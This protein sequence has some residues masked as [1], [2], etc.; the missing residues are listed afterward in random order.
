M[1]RDDSAPDAAPDLERMVAAVG[2]LSA[3]RFTVDG[4][5]CAGGPAAADA[6]DG[7]PTL[8]G[9]VPVV[10]KLAREIYHR[11]YTRGGAAG[12]RMA[13]AV[14]RRDH[15]VR[16]SQANCGRGTWEP[17]WRISGPQEDG[18]VAVEK[19]G[20]TFWV[21]P[22]RLRPSDGL[23]PGS[24][25]RVK[26][27]KELRELQRGFY[28]AV[29]DGGKDGEEDE[30]EPLARFYWH[31]TAAGA[32]PFVRLLTASLNP[33]GIAFRAKVLSD[34]VSY[35]R[36]D[37]G[38]LYL[39]RR[40]E[41]ALRDTIA[42]VWRGARGD[43]RPMVPLLTRQLAP[44]LGVAEDPGDG[45]SFG[46][47]R[48]ILV[49]RGLWRAFQQERRTDA[50]RLA[51]VVETFRET[52]LDPSRPHLAPGSADSYLP[53]V[54]APARDPEPRRRPA[55]ASP[56]TLL[57]AA[58]NI[59]DALVARA[60]W[61]EEKCNWMG[62]CRDEAAAPHEPVIPTSAALGCS[63]YDG[64]PG[65]ALFLAE[66][67]A[68][69]GGESY[70]RTAR[71]A[72]RQAL[73]RLRDEPGVLAA[74]GLFAGRLGVAWAAG[75][76]AELCAADDL[77]EDA[78]SLLAATVAAL[79]TPA[80]GGEE[81]PSDLLAGNAGGIL[82]LLHLQRRTA[83]Q[84]LLAAAVTLGDELCSRAR[85]TGTTWSWEPFPAAGLAAGPPLTG[86][87]HGAAGIGLALME[88]FAATGRADFLT[89][90][91]RAFAYEAELFDAARRNW[92]DLRVYESDGRREGDGE[93]TFRT[94]WCHGAPGIVLSR[95]RALELD[96]EPS[97]TYRDEAEAGLGT[98]LRVLDRLQETSGSDA[99]L[100]HGVAGLGEV[101]LLAGQVL[102][103]KRY[104][105]RAEEA[106]RKLLGHHGEKGDWPSGAPSR[107]PNPS[108]LLGDAGIGHWLLRL[109]AG[110]AVP[111]VLLPFWNR[112]N[113]PAPG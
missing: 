108:L 77:A 107:G 16:L 109:H 61:H 81:H 30:D 34:P 93:P 5:P 37:A 43:L 56:G 11:L 102:E 82:A 26:V 29:G 67:Y 91:R 10:R 71:G 1:P 110:P 15:L 83:A 40:H 64:T 62:R 33:T 94:A 72:I 89:G 41:P 104:V 68:Q 53:L 79:A 3:D 57:A 88:L 112:I 73:G 49:A 47:H 31:L 27:G 6:V 96:P 42:A 18:R 92:P 55:A 54:P 84:S 8:A 87:A 74:R 19:D 24:R 63:L 32:A 80:G 44:G 46:Q 60:W 20:L 101:V 2:L 12:E 111:S 90:A 50:E 113:R 4:E 98:T 52:G 105:A 70:R 9:E 95:L 106:A 35:R 36:A 38:V 99:S 23:T 59:G 13:D 39:A 17:G 22:D 75:R 85:K 76:S 7:W 25:C 100:C 65:V 97:A 14:A 78:E 51:T 45:S 86:L 21:T 66:L 103:R 28:I 69:T 58:R 48:S